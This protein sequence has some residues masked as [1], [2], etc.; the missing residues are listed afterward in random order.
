MNKRTSVTNLTMMVNFDSNN[1]GGIDVRMA[2]VRCV[3]VECTMRGNSVVKVVAIDGI[4]F[5]AECGM[6]LDLPADFVITS[7]CD[8]PYL[9]RQIAEE[10][11]ERMT[12]AQMRV[13]EVAASERLIHR[14]V[15]EFAA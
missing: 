9:A 3:S 1:E 11:E 12:D 7:L 5:K 6:V 10:D 2:Q 8:L 4:S 15:R 13:R 14:G